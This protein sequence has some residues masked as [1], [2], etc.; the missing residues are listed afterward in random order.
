MTEE[1]SPDWGSEEGEPDAGWYVWNVFVKSMQFKDTEP[2]KEKPFMLIHCLVEDPPDGAPSP[3]SGY[4][5]SFR[6][7]IHKKS[8]GWAFY[9]LKKFGYNPELL[10]DTERPQLKKHEVEGLHG[11]LLVNVTLN[12]NTGTTNIDVKGFDQ[13]DGK[14]LEE[15]MAKAIAKEKGEEYVAP[16][17]EPQQEKEIDVREDVRGQAPQAQPA[18]EGDGSWLDSLPEDSPSVEEAFKASDEDLPESLR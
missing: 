3:N 7:Y 2:G 8:R 5:F 12:E 11:K 13:I 18:A 4:G 14:E 16:G 15:K 10:A 6:V 1:F 9:F 17:K